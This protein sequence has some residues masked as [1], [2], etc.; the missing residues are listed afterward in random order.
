MKLL[1]A[2]LDVKTE[3]FLAPMAAVTRGEAERAY[4]EIL[5][6]EGTLIH[7]HPGDFP[8]YEI[9]TYDERTG[10]IAPLMAEGNGFAMPPRLLIDAATVLQLRKEA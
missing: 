4:V 7:K 6:S 2:M 9:G 8:L 10:V 3:T 1:F 5:Q